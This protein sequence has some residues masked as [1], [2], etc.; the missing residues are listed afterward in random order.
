M[1]KANRSV[2]KK[3]FVRPDRRILQKE[4]TRVEGEVG[5]GGNRQGGRKEFASGYRQR[6]PP[7]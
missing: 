1:E 3:A 4:L 5:D 6:A 7:R 2:G